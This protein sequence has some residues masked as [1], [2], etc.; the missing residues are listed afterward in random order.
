MASKVIIHLRYKAGTKGKVY[1]SIQL[2]VFFFYGRFK[3]SNTFRQI[4]QTIR[5]SK[6]N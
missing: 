5:L 3:L 1:L 2:I 4:I 6:R